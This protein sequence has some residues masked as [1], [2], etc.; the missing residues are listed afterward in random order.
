MHIQISNS[1]GVPVYRQIVNQVKY[2]AAS[3]VLSVGQE[4]PPIRVLAEQLL[5]TPNT[6]V[7]AY[8]FLEAEGVVTKRRGSGTFVADLQS[9]LKRQEQRK[10]L[11][12]RADAL[13]VEALQLGF[14]LE[15]VQELLIHRQAALV[16]RLPKSARKGHADVG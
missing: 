5:V 16:K 11:T 9:P 15:E 6:V 12:E 4:L 8:A 2:L 14:S 1:D 13:L 7:K 3:G 10:I